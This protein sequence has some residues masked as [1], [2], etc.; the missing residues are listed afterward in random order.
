MKREIYKMWPVLRS[1]LWWILIG[2]LSVI[3]SFT[4]KLKSAPKS[5]GIFT[6]RSQ[7][8]PLGT[9]VG[10][11]VF[12]PG[13]LCLS[14]F[15][16]SRMCTHLQFNTK[17]LGPVSNNTS[18][19]LLWRADELRRDAHPGRV[20]ASGLHSLE[21]PGFPCHKEEIGGV[22]LGPERWLSG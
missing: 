5:P 13:C 22:E 1:R 12:A 17:P 20:E 15:C 16:V 21:S 6:S 7:T 9:T 19:S 3:C 11:F 14:I 18:D 10:L 2:L 8:P 4:K